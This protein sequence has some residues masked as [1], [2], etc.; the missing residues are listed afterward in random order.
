MTKVFVSFSKALVK[1]S[2]SLVYLAHNIRDLLLIKVDSL[3]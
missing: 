3:H 1:P 2:F